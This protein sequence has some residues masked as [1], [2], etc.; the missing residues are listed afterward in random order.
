[1]EPIEIPN[2]ITL[3][4]NASLKRIIEAYKE[5]LSF[6][7]IHLA[8]ASK[9]SLKQ[10]L[11]NPE[12][13][14]PVRSIQLPPIN[15]TNFLPYLN[16]YIIDIDNRLNKFRNSTKLTQQEKIKILAFLITECSQMELQ[17]YP[18]YQL[19]GLF[20]F[21]WRIE[22]T[23]VPFSR[24]I[25]DQQS[26]EMISKEVTLRYEFFTLLKKKLELCKLRLEAE[27]PTDKFLSWKKTKRPQLIITEIILA[28]EEKEYIQYLSDQAKTEFIERLKATFSLTQFKWSE[29][30]SE[31]NKRDNIRF[32]NLR[33]LAK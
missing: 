15:V 10:F 31:I 13:K 7:T 27:R 12:K 4:E 19:L 20:N 29:M 2:R 8:I 21:D 30:V 3:N 16:E 24:L 5:E 9:F 26:V 11:N 23:P 22:N 17:Y 33:T 25:I 6:T 32:K 14:Y 28:L 1:M 18:Y